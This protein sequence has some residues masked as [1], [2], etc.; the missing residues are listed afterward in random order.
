MKT[1]KGSIIC[2]ISDSD[3]QKIKFIFELRKIRSFVIIILKI[4]Q[5]EN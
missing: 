2:T 5:N 4:K 3:D 1:F